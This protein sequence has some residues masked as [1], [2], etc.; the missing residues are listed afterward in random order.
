MSACQWILLRGE[1]KDLACGLKCSSNK[2]YSRHILVKPQNLYLESNYNDITKK[3]LSIRSKEDRLLS[4]QFFTSKS[5]ISK[6]MDILKPFLKN[7]ISSILE[8]SF[9]SGEFLD[10]L[11]LSFPEAKINGIEY[12]KDLYSMSKSLIKSD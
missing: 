4:G 9:G 12:D 1:R 5:M 10:V 11:S 2:F 3:F 7:N 6:C 8:A